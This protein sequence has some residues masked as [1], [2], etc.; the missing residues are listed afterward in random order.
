MSPRVYDGQGPPRGGG[1]CPLPA[2]RW[3]RPV[4]AGCCEWWWP[5][6]RAKIVTTVAKLEKGPEESGVFARIDGGELELLGSDG[7][8]ERR[9]PAGTGLVAAFAPGE[10]D[11]V[12]A[13]TG[14]DERGV[15]AAARALDRRSLRDAYAVAVLPGGRVEKLP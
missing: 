9:A 7:E 5:W 2:R 14:V 15:E 13:V 10:E 12:W 6:E 4:P 11:T 3:A 8:V 1:G